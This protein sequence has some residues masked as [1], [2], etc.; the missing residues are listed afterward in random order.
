MKYEIES[1]EGFLSCVKKIKK[2]DAKNFE[3]KWNQ[4]ESN[5]IC[6]K[7]TRN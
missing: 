2:Q 3:T 1:I 6:S 7:G 5:R 4:I